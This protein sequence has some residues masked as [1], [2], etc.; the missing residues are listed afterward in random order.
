MKYTSVIFIDKTSTTLQ[1][2]VNLEN[3]SHLTIL[4]VNVLL[5]GIRGVPV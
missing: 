4:T 1:Y 3:N 2:T 5:L